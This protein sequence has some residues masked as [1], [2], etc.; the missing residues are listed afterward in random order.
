M[1]FLP[2][3]QKGFRG[4]FHKIMELQKRCSGY[5]E[6]SLRHWILYLSSFKKAM[7]YV[8]RFAY[9]IENESISRPAFRRYSWIGRLN[10][11]RKRIPWYDSKPHEIVRNCP[12]Q[13]TPS[14]GWAPSHAFSSTLRANHTTAVWKS[15]NFLYKEKY[16]N[17]GVVLLLYDWRGCFTIFVYSICTD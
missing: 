1:F 10:G 3:P 13:A 16:Y 5:F 14:K 9:L 15:I 11:D 4:K 6:F 17:S 7:L 8:D 2:F 12:V